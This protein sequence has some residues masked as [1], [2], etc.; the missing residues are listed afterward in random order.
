MDSGTTSQLAISLPRVA[1]RRRSRSLAWRSDA[2]AVLVWWLRR[3]GGDVLD[4]VGEQ[5]VEGL[6]IRGREAP[7]YLTVDLAERA[8]DIGKQPLAGS[9][10]RD[11]RAPAVGA[12]TAPLDQACVFEPVEDRHEVCGVDA[13]QVHQGLLGRRTP[14]EQ[15]HQRQH[16]VESQ[17]GWGDGLLDSSTRSADDLDDEQAGRGP[18]V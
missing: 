9:C 7:E 15:V 10:E 14:F 5:G 3:A 16:F 1:R 4:D 2:S 18:D 12:I 8:V 17:P 6:P 11:N 13:H